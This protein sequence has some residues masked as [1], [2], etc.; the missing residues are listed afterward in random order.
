MAVH[1]E[2]DPGRSDKKQTGVN[3]V[4][5]KNAE[6]YHNANHNAGDNT[7]FV[8]GTIFFVAPLAAAVFARKGIADP[9]AA[10]ELPDETE[11]GNKRNP[12]ERAFHRT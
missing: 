4:P 1:A 8:A 6:Y 7:L 10:D 3:L 9:F 5:E 11:Q 2:S 12:D